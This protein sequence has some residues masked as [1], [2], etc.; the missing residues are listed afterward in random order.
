M[1]CTA[2]FVEN[3]TGGGGMRH[4]TITKEFFDKIAS[5][6]KKIEYRKDI[7]FY[8]KVF[9]NPVKNITFHYRRRVYLDCEIS[10]VE[11]IKRPDFLSK[12][13]FIDTENCFAIHISSCQVRNGK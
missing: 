9:A 3:I 10:H 4:M 2:V 8:E 6:D 1:K 13:K 5:G 12:S 11:K 7:P